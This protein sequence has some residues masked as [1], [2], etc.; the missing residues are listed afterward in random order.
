MA[1]GLDELYRALSEYLGLK[2]RLEDILRR[3]EASTPEEVEARLRRGELPVGRSFEEYRR[4]YDDLADAIAIQHELS[5]LEERM[6][7]MLKPPQC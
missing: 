7:R 6:R 3:Y 4:I 2:K 1:E 5:M